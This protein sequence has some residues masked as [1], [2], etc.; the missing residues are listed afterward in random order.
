[1]FDDGQS[2]LRRSL[3]WQRGKSETLRKITFPPERNIA[4]PTWSWMA[5][6]GGIDFLELPLGGVNWQK[7]EVHSPWNITA[8]EVYHTT[9]QTGSIELSA[10]ARKFEE[11][12]TQGKES[13][14][15]YDIPENERQALRCVVMGKRKA[16]EKEKV[17]LENARHYV[18][19]IAP[20]PGAPKIYER[21]GVGYMPGKFI[22][23]NAPGP[24]GL[25]KV[26]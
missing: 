3:L 18:L 19:F 16:K 23:L 11:Q 15:V 9:D 2:L 26:R 14:V 7:D 24:S 12:G 10:I 17:A 25:V 5:Y 1:V 22:E 21:V 13:M 8:P 6:E 20:Q 4:V